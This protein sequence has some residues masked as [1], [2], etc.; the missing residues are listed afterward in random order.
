MNDD[1]Y[2][3]RPN[4]NPGE[5]DFSAFHPLDHRPWQCG[6]LPGGWRAHL[7]YGWAFKWR[8]DIKGAT[9]CKIRLHEGVQFWSRQHTWKG[10]RNC[11]KRLTERQE[12]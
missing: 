7:K 2:R 1:T 10:C 9:F 11:G 5:I 8:A 6:G 12:G 3:P 4:I